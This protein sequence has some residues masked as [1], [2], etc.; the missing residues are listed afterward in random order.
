VNPEAKENLP[1]ARRLVFQEKYSEATDLINNKIMAKP[2]HQLQYQ[3]AGD[4]L[5]SFSKSEKSAEYRRELNLDTAVA[6]VTYVSDGVRFTR[7]ILSTPIDQVIAVRI[8]ADRPGSISFETTLKTPQNATVSSEGVDTIVLNG[9]N[10][11]AEGIPGTLKF[12]VRVR[13]I[14]EGGKISSSATSIVVENADSALVLVAVATSYRN[15]MDVGGD[16]ESLTKK[17]IA[18]AEKKS[19][20]DMRN[21]HV[22]EHQRL[23]SRTTLDLGISDSAKLPTDERLQ[24]FA[25]GAKDPQLA[26]LYFQFG[27]YLL[28]SSSRPGTQPVNLQGIWNESM[29]PPWGSKYTVNINTEM[30]YWPAEPANLAECVEPLIQLLKEISVTGARTAKE[31]YGAGGWVCHHNTDAWRA[32]APIDCA[33]WGMWP[34]GGAWLCMHLWEHYQFSGDRKFL[35]EAYPIM[36]GAAEFFIDTLVEEPKGKF[37]VTCPSVSPENLHPHSSSICAGPAMDRQILR[38]LFDACINAS[39]ILGI[40]EDFRKKTESVRKRLPP[41]RI[42]KG[43][44]LQEWLEDWDMEAKEQQHRH[45][46]H[47]YAL[48]PSAQIT[49][50]STPELAKAAAKTLDV[51]GDISTGWAIAWRLNLQA[52]LRDA[53]RAYRILRALLDP[54]RTYP[55]MFDAHPPFQIDGNF[56]GTCGIAEMLLQSHEED[57]E[58]ISSQSSVISKKK[59]E[60]VLN[61]QEAHPSRAFIIRLL[62]ALPSAWP[63]GSVTGLRARGGLEVDMSWKNGKLK[64]AAI[65]SSIGSSCILMY[66]NKQV[67]I[68]IAPGQIFKIENADSPAAWKD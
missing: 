7:E 31:M 8:T 58:V 41:D 15:Y 29:N 3:T 11:S 26:A 63:D 60:L 45:V 54:S 5:F 68:K 18:G 10:G 62:P 34:T 67:S 22:A 16:P 47:L 39:G 21:S 56:G 49:P 40:D 66:G 57:K 14:P 35:A 48:F 36:K 37:L 19:F 25:D 65:R 59:K 6:S 43:G 17:Q 33:F 51:R 61:K 28:I 2:L 4:V 1:E 27:R 23:F 38:D 52:R 55:N 53:E 32:T 20:D 44:Q 13:I 9:V 46:S 12:Q 42:G 30:N 24:N 64:T 50:E